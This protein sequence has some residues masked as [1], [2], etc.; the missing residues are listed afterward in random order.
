M[1][2]DRVGEAKGGAFPLCSG[3]VLVEER[4]RRDGQLV[5]SMAGFLSFSGLTLPGLTI[6]FLF[7]LRVFTL[8]TAGEF[9]SLT[10]TPYGTSFRRKKKQENEKE[11]KET[12][13]VMAHEKIKYWNR[14]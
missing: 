7:F 14:L 10:N 2:Q 5:G 1:K 11:K 6:C 12:P 13:M 3:A 8:V 9:L 4:I